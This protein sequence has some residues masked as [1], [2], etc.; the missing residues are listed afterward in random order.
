M[1][2]ITYITTNLINGKQYVG[3]HST[4]NLDDSYLGSG[5]LILRAI[6]KYGKENFKREIL[7]VSESKE[8]AFDLQEKYINEY[9]TLKPIGYNLSPKGGHF[10]SGSLSEE[11]KRKISISKK[12]KETWMKGKTH[13]K[14]SIEKLKVPHN[15]EWNKKVSLANKGKV[16]WNKG[17]KGIYST[18]T[19]EKMQNSAKKRTGEKNGFFGK[20]HTEDTIKKIKD[21]SVNNSKG[22]KNG[23]Y[24]KKHSKESKMKMSNSHK[25]K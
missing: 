10:V 9:E 6:K 13:K 3:D 16:P 25:L 18:E 1:K 22:E 14:E 17:K 12:G 7:E 23:M 8:E 21:T 15:E 19:I 20:K 2:H 4:D 11:T 5:K 24:G